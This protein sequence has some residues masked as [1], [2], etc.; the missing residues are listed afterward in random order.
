MP[1]SD[2]VVGVTSEQVLTVSRPGQRDGLWLLSLSR[3]GELW[4]Q[5]V[6]QLSLLQVE[7]LDT[8]S[9]GSSQPVSGWRESQSVNLRRSVQGVQG[10]VGVQVPQDDD[11][12]LTSGS[13]Q[14]SIWGDNNTGNVTGVAD[15]VS[16]ELV[17]VQ[18]P[19]LI[20]SIINSRQIRA[21]FSQSEIL[22][23]K[24]CLIRSEATS[25]VAN[26]RYIIS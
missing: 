20:V 4:L 23:I 11:T 8:G 18:V 21:I 25:E 19:R 7:D 22:V 9:S 13:V 1:D 6:Q 10:L 17:L 2:D 3:N 26:I 5:L 12:V 24:I 16:V 14:R 15:E